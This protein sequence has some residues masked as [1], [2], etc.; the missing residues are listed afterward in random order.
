MYVWNDKMCKRRSWKYEKIQTLSKKS[1]QI[2]KGQ[3]ELLG[4]KNVVSKIRKWK[5]QGWVKVW[6]DV[7]YQR[8]R[9]VPP[10]SVHAAA[11]DKAVENIK[12][13]LRHEE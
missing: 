7:T 11:R 12:E 9:E 6:L 2:W 3:I 5:T 13:K 4:M 8:I 1:R 10:V